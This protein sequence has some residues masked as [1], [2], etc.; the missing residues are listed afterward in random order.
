[1]AFGLA[2]M[3]YHWKAYD[4]IFLKLEVV[5]IKY[6]TGPCKGWPKSQTSEDKGKSSSAQLHI[7]GRHDSIGNNKNRTED[8]IFFSLFKNCL[9]SEKGIQIM[10]HNV[11]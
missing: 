9:T 2:Q 3:R 4:S 5:K 11:S 10:R 1:M 8:C 6:K 7:G